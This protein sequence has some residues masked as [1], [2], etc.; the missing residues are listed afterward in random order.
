VARQK[1][2]NKTARS[3]PVLAALEAPVACDYAAAGADATARLHA[4]LKAR[5]ADEGMGGVYEDLE[6][7]LVAVLARME[8]VPPGP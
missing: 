3:R 6:R 8:Q 4:R 1:A 5:V 7:P 2:A